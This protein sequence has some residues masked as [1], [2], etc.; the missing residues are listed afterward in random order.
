MVRI[1]INS[2]GKK[3]RLKSRKQI[4]GLFNQGRKITIFPFRLMY[5]LIPG[6]FNLKA[7]FTVSSRNFPRAVDRN[8]IK[9]LSREAYRLQK[10]KLPELLQKNKQLIHLFFIYTGREVPDFPQVQNS[11]QLLLDKLVKQVHDGNSS[12]T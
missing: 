3:E 6:D 4:D 9:R 8:R 1:K 5:Q 12:N 2:L 10:N 7:G 11:I